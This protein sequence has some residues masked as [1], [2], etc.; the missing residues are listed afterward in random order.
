VATGRKILSCFFSAR[1]QGKIAMVTNSPI[2][3][4][5]LLQTIREAVKSAGGKR[6]G[7]QKFLAHSKL[8]STDIYRHY[9]GWRHA[10]RAAGIDP[11]AHNT[12]VDSATLLA[13]WAGVADKLG[14]IPTLHEYNLSG[15][16]GTSTIMRRFGSWNKIPH[17]FREY[18][19]KSPR[20]KPLLK[21]L[22]PSLAR[23]RT[24]RGRYSA[25]P[26]PKSAS[27]RPGRP[28]CGLPIDF[29]ALRHAP[30][31]ELGVVCLF[32]MLADKLGFLLEAF[33]AA[34]PD[35]QAKRLIGPDIWQNVTIEFE[36]ESRNYRDH[37]H[38]IDGC[39]IIV[40]W[41]HNWP[42]CPKNLEV[43]ALK[44]EIERLGS[45]SLPAMKRVAS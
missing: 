6:I 45:P 10:L 9:T 20:W 35:C 24:R 40:C 19:A 15:R 17:A 41:E 5:T 38:P 14:R 33:Q 7:M 32:G 16:H 8:K 26:L 36:H 30:V 3:C 11:T 22:A 39:D 12:P 13:D 2:D 18:A 1:H 34:F 28:A 25:R 27:R 29:G 44:D 42:D 4:K 43:I 31:N 23:P 37:H 21:K